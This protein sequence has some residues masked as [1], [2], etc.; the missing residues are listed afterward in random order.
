[1]RKFTFEYDVKVTETV[2]V[3]AKTFTEA[4]NKFMSDRPE[5]NAFR[6]VRPKRNRELSAQQIYN[7][8][9][10]HLLKQGVQSLSPSGS[11]MM[12]SPTGLRCAV[13]CL[14]PPSDYT[15]GVSRYA[16]NKPFL[17][18]LKRRGVDYTKHG[19]LLSQLTIA[20]DSGS[21]DWASALQRVAI[22]NGLQP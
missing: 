4:A 19:K 9:K 11:C 8:V 16:M 3:E 6:R 10:K 18:K 13:G 2:T 7:K 15:S 5:V 17:T 22:A 12:L 21:S 20:H 14:L 1:M